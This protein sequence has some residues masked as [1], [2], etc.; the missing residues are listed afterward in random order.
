MKGGREKLFILSI[1][2]SLPDLFGYPLDGAFMDSDSN[3][4]LYH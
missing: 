3:K 4:F 1:S 2:E